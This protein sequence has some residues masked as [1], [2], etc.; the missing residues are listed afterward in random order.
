MIHLCLHLL[1]NLLL[2]LCH[3]GQLI[4]RPFLKLSD[5]LSLQLPRVRLHIPMFPLHFRFFSLHLHQ[6]LPSQLQLMLQFLVFLPISDDLSLLNLEIFVK[7]RKTLAEILIFL[8]YGLEIDHRFRDYGLAGTSLLMG[9]GSPSMGD[10]G[11]SVFGLLGQEG[12]RGGF[13]EVSLLLIH[14]LAVLRGVLH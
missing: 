10:R 9:E 12:F 7:F 13:G 2:V 5:Q 6:S 8:A 11:V 4:R 3:L 1:Y 14:N